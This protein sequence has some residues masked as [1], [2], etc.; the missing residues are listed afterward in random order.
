MSTPKDAL[1]AP[2]FKIVRQQ[3]STYMTD[4]RVLAIE[5]GFLIDGE[6]GMQHYAS[7]DALRQA[8]L[9]FAERFVEEVEKHRARVEAAEAATE[10]K[11][12]P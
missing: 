2:S 3:K 1:R 4:L 7:L 11:D 8:L 9:Q 6:I 10:A 12:Q 5:N